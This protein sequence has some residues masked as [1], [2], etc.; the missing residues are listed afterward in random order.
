MFHPQKKT[1]N[2]ARSA[3]AGVPT[4]AESCYIGRFTG[5]SRR[6]LHLLR[7]KPMN[8]M[9]R[10]MHRRMH[11]RM[12]GD[13]AGAMQL[14]QSKL[15]QSR[16]DSPVRSRFALLD[17]VNIMQIDSLMCVASA[18]AS[19]RVGIRHSVI[20]TAQRGCEYRNQATLQCHM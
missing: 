8:A 4:T 11:I 13:K 2:V 18:D 15:K 20:Q 14:R 6:R 9:H 10:R 19:S 17:V 7:T 3:G 5:V 1:N 16:D 12:L